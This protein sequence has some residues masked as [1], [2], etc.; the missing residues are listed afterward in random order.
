MRIEKDMVYEMIAI[1]VVILFL[2]TIFCLTSGAQSSYPVAYGIEDLPSVIIYGESCIT[3]TRK[4]PGA[5]AGDVFQMLS[6]DYKGKFLV[7]EENVSR[8]NVKFKECNPAKVTRRAPS[9][10]I[11]WAVFRVGVRK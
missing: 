9:I 8:D 2:I 11:N 10:H 7:F 3:I 1:A 5:R 6:D 4:A